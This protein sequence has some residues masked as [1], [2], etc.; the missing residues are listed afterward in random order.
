MPVQL[1]AQE[2]LHGQLGLHLSLQREA[3]TYDEV[4]SHHKASGHA[5][6][7]H[8]HS[9]VSSSSASSLSESKVLSGISYSRIIGL[10][11]SFIFRYFPSFCSSRYPQ[12]SVGFP[13]H[14]P[15]SVLSALQTHL[16]Y[17]VVYPRSR[18]WTCLGHEQE[19]QI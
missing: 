19:T 14:Y 11:G 13:M 4:T 7:H 8:I 18:V 9:P 17:I 1:C 10:L 15:Y 12:Y 6:V 2:I 16:A 5:Y 3:I